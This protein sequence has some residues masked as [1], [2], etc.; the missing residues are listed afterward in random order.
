MGTQQVTPEELA[1]LLKN[2][3]DRM[4]QMESTITALTEENKQLRDQIAAGPSASGPSTTE[5]LVK[6]INRLFVSEKKAKVPKPHDYDGDQ[7]K[8]PTFCREAETYIIDQGLD[9]ERDTEKAIN[10][11]AGYMT[12][13]AASWYTIVYATRAQNEKMW[14][15]REEFWTDMRTRFGE[16]DPTFAARTKLS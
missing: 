10:I 1:R 15:S 9:S 5:S 3:G 7:Q 13:N 14:A 8:L 4:T 16:A 12:G 6:T 11:I 2:M